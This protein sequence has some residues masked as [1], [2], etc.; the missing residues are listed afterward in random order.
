MR[1]GRPTILESSRT[2]FELD[3]LLVFAG[4]GAPEADRLVSLGLTEGSGNLHPGQGTANRRFFFRNTM[5]ELLWVSDERDVRSNAIAPTRLW[6]RLQWRRTGASPFGI[7][8]RGT[9]GLARALP[10]E[11]W[12]YQ[13]PYLANG[14]EI[15]VARATAAAEPMLFAISSG[16]R[17]DAVPPDRREPIDHVIGVREITAVRV[18]LAGSRALT[19]TLQAVERLGIAT[20]VRG[21]EHLMELSFDDASRGMSADFRPEL[22][23]VLYW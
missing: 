11:T 18:T 16:G 10:F 3:H 20:F 5:L 22:P 4:V 21:T 9:A 6:E 13:P 17:P 2:P 15:P 7:C 19:P 14:M 23:L 1:S 8:F 12:N